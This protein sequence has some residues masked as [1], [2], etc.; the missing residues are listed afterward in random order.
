MQHRCS[1]GA[2]QVQQ[3]QQVQVHRCRYGDVQVQRRC[4]GGAE[5]RRAEM[6]IQRCRGAE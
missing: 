2:A 3:V 4:R 1:T 5:C 6:Q